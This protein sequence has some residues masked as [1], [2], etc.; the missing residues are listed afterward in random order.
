MIDNLLPNHAKPKVNAITKEQSQKIKSNVEEVKSP[1]K[2]IY[3][4]LLKAGCLELR[5][6]EQDKKKMLGYSYEYHTTI[7]GHIIQ[8]CKK[9]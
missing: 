5:K 9:F 4:A 2:V 8:C 7:M 3:E 6:V 1:I